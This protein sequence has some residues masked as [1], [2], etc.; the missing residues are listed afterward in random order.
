MVVTSA[1]PLRLRV[2]AAPPPVTAWRAGELSLAVLSNSSSS[3]GAAPAAV[4]LFAAV[5]VS[6]N[7]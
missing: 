4:P 2:L 3:L 7:D 6:Q 5:E 1:E